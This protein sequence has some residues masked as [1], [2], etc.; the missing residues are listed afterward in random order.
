[1]K[2]KL[3]IASAGSG[4][5]TFL[6]ER[7]LSILNKNVLITTFTEDNAR[8]IYAKIVSIK[9]FI[10][11]SITVKTWFSLL[12]QHGV[13]PYQGC[14]GSEFSDIDIGF[15]LVNGK[16][17]LRYNNS[18]G[19]P[20][21]WPETEA[22]KYYLNSNNQ[23]YSDKISHFFIKVNKLTNG[24]IIDRLSNI[25]D[26]IFV[27][28]VQD[29]VGYDLDILK[30]FLSSKSSII[31]VGDP[32]QATYET[33]HASKYKKYSEGKVK[34]FISNELGKSIF[35]EIDESTL[36]AS[37]RNNQIICNYSSRLYPEF[38]PS[39]SCACLSCHKNKDGHIG[40]FLVNPKDVNVYLSRYNPVQLRHNSNVNCN[41]NF[42]V[43]N[44]GQSK[45]LSFDRVLIYPT[46]D[47]IKWII[48][49]KP[50]SNKSTKA[51]LYV[52][53]TRARLS[54]ALVVEHMPNMPLNGLE[55]FVIT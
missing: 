48:H 38:S 41:I 17:G 55:S 34:D 40:V 30:L 12:L 16:S 3:I 28:E 23:I 21:Y 15:I 5:T 47:M 27:D 37:H 2:N 35:C 1:M 22:K 8:E 6:V 7:A 32:R 53:L 43:K 20:V 49:N 52:G 19:F 46:Q 44:L 31:L 42:P 54:V 33:H 29:L 18:K 50:I 45:G 14:L 4:K 39:K 9:G 10:P 36:N 11:E 25:F 13:R 24:A 51:R 26:Y